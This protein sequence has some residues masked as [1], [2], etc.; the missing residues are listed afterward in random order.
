MTDGVFN[1][2]LSMIYRNGRQKIR[3]DIVDLNDH[4]NFT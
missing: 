3:K 4:I 1:I 2:P